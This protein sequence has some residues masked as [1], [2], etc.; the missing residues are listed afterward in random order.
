MKLTK[1]NKITDCQK[2][3]FERVEKKELPSLR[4]WINKQ[5]KLYEEIKK[6]IDVMKSH[7][8]SVTSCTISTSI[9]ATKVLLM[10]ASLIDLSV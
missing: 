7:V 3:F 8:R 2:R 9:Q 10:Q 4:E 6:K 5:E 1:S